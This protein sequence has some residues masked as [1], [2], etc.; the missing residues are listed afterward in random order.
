ML[1][2]HTLLFFVLAISV[3]AIPVSQETPSAPPNKG[4]GHRLK[5]MFKSEPYEHN[6]PAEATGQRINGI[7]KTHVLYKA[8]ED[9]ALQPAKICMLIQDGR[10]TT[11]YDLPTQKLETAQALAESATWS[12]VTKVERF[13]QAPY[14][15]SCLPQI[16]NIMSDCYHFV[17]QVTPRSHGKHVSQGPPSSNG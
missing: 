11:L 17:G 8:A 2:L 4:I 12:R 6:V 16:E 13:E 14:N 1:F 7:W 15:V 5:N 10:V 3:A 9:E